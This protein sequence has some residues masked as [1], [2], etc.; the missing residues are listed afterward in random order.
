MF[1]LLEQTE[2]M[3]MCLSVVLAEFAVTNKP[4]ELDLNFCSRKCGFH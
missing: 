4:K 1:L 2:P 3:E